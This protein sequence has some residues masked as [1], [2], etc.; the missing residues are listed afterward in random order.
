VYSLLLSEFFPPIRAIFVR[1]YY[2]VTFPLRDKENKYS[3]WDLSVYVLY[4]AFTTFRPR[5][6]LMFFFCKVFSYLDLM[7]LLHTSTSLAESPFRS[8]KLQILRG[9]YLSAATYYTLPLSGPV[10][11]IASLSPQREWFLFLYL[12]VIPIPRVSYTFYSP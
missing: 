1:L 6:V 12:R 11:C 9:I 7:S 2:F 10:C 3:Q 5:V 4:H 8:S